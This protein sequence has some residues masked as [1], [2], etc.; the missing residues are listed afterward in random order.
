MIAGRGKE[1]PSKMLLTAQNDPSETAM[2][3][4][5]LTKF[6][7]W[8]NQATIHA[9]LDVL[10]RGI[11]APDGVDPLALARSV[12]SALTAKGW[13]AAA[14]TEERNRFA[15][16]AVE[17]MQDAGLDGDDGLFEQAEEILSA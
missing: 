5:L 14:S 3:R 13:Q 10:C 12:S 7:T 4:R 11:E 6:L 16:V 1:A 15:A 8:P 2:R 9:G 17:A